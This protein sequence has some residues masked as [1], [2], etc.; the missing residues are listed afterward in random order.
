MYKYAIYYGA[1]WLRERGTE[2]EFETKE[3]ARIDAEADIENFISDW[4]YEGVEYDRD[5]FYVEIEECE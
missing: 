2:T 5:M 3:E 4:K 1:E